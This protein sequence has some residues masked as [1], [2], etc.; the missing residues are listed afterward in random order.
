MKKKDYINT[1][2]VEFNFLPSDYTNCTGPL[3][4]LKSLEVVEYTQTA[5]I[6]KVDTCYSLLEHLSS[7]EKYFLFIKF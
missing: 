1:H 2:P 7:I 4:C 5:A 3:N 6:S